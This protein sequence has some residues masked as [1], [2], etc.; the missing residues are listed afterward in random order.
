MSSSPVPIRD[1][2]RLWG[3]ESDVRLDERESI[4]YCRAL[5][6]GHYENFSVLSSLVPSSLR[7]DFAAVYGFCR[8]S[9]DLA[10][11]IGDRTESRALLQWWRR[12][13]D[14]CIDGHPRHPVM[15]ALS[16]TIRRHDLPARPFHDLIDAFEQDQELTRY[17]SW[18]QL[19]HYCARSANPVGRLVLML[20]GEP[21]DD[22]RFLPSDLICTALQL[23]NHWQDVSRDILER[24]R[25]YIPTELLEI[26]RFEQRLRDSASQGYSVDE[27]F[28]D[29]SRQVIR[30]CVDRTEAMFQSGRVL[31][32]RIKPESRPVIRL[33]IDGGSHVLN[34]VRHW[35]YET[36]I[37]RPRLSKFVKLGLVARAW[38]GA[39]LAGRGR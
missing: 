2:V 27:A 8:W 7:D 28:L 14:D 34:L 26:D 1:Q 30:S 4:A 3:P 22:E 16:A 33:F 19:L 37:H 5:A 38:T 9:D 17:E 13:L 23:T 29:E 21:R 12:E 24:D 39:R 31:L 18:D 15:C 36:A 11:E 35:N 25:I 10:D 20:L 32:D 6:G